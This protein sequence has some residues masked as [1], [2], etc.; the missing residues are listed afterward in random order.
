VSNHKYDAMRDAAFKSK[1]LDPKYHQPLLA[2]MER[3]L[4]V[5]NVPPEYLFKS[6]NGVCTEEEVNW[7]A[8]VRKAG[9][10]RG[11]MYLGKFGIEVEERMLS[12]SAMWLRNYIDV[13]YT[14]FNVAIQADKN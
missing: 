10:K 2:D 13:R 6:T 14:S 7:A 11:L 4:D 1:I 8:D 5:A 9:N 12:L 3:L